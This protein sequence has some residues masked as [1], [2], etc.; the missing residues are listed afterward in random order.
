M[1]GRGCPFYNQCSSAR[2][3]GFQSQYCNN[4]AKSRKCPERPMNYN[5]KEVSRNYNYAKGSHETTRFGQ[6][7]IIA[8][9][10]IAIIGFL[11]SKGCLPLT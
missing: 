3:S 5:N 7:L 8:V 9:V 10:I 1:L 6:G 2:K 11:A 4:E